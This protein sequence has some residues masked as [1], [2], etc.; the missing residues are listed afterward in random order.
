VIVSEGKY[1]I[2]DWDDPRLAPPERDAWFCMHWNWATAAFNKALRENGIEYAL[3][4]ERM[5]YY[6]YQYFFFYLKK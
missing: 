6:C 4:I 1:H 2:V 5:A 3:R